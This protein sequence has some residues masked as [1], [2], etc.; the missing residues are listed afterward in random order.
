M[1]WLGYSAD[2]QV[3]MESSSEQATSVLARF[4]ADLLST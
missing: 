1:L 2:F 4:T 3:L